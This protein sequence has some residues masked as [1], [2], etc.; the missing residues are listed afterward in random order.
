MHKIA[1]MYF[2][3]YWSRRN[4][5]QKEKFKLV[6]LYKKYRDHKKISRVDRHAQLC[7]HCIH[8][9]YNH[10]LISNTIF[11]TISSRFHLLT[12]HVPKIKKKTLFVEKMSVVMGNGNEKMAG[13]ELHHW[14]MK[15][16]INKANCVRNI[17]V[18]ISK[19]LKILF[20]CILI[21]E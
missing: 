15:L 12:E 3:N 18:H 17:F 9:Q 8:R 19:D 20:L 1:Y 4:F 2:Q 13:N 6:D 7:T 14:G 21:S 11:S 16:E 10:N 5:V